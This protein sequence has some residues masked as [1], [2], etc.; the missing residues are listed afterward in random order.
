MKKIGNRLFFLLCLVGFFFSMVFGK[1][2][3]NMAAKKKGN[4]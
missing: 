3:G 4:N 1:R 2:F